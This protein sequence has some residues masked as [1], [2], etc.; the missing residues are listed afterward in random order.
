M[1]DDINDIGA[2]D[3]QSVAEEHSRLET[4]QLEY[5]LTWRYLSRCLPASGSILEIDAATGRRSLRTMKATTSLRRR[6]AI[7]GS[8]FYSR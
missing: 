4:H 1:I 6:N 7:C 3:D 8:T 2:L 5:D